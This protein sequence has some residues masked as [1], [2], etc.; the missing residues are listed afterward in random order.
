MATVPATARALRLLQRLEE[1][2]AWRLLRAD[3]A[4]IV[5]A[6]LKEHLDGDANRRDAEDLY[7]RIDADLDDLRTHGLSL[8]QTAQAY[9]KAWRDAGFLVRRTT[10]DTRTETLELSGAG[11]AA[12]RFLESRDAPRRSLTESRLASLS[13]QL[14][15]LAIDTDPSSERRLAR[16]REER[17]AI[18]ARIAA[19]EEGRDDALAGERATERVQDL[20]AQAAEVPDDFARVRTEFEQLNTLLRRRILESGE[21][22]R[23]VLDDVFRGVDLIAESD[24][25][26][27]F[28]GFSAL[29]LDPALGTAFEE[30]VRHVLER[31][32]ARALSIAERRALREFLTTL[33]DRSAEIHDVIT[34]FAR[35]LRRYVRSQ[36][37]QRDRVLRGLIQ[38]ALGEARESASAIKPWA[39]L[40]VELALTHVEIRSAG[41]LTLHDPAEM[42]APREVEAHAGEVA[43]LAALR[44]LAR[45][46]EI[47]FDEL[48]ND[49]NAALGRARAHDATAVVSVGDVLAVNPATQGVASVVGLLALAARWG[50]VPAEAEPEE[51]HWTG[52]DGARRRARV[53][54]HVFTGRIP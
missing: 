23:E 49:V 3:N 21:S 30:D 2:A 10:P 45:A 13:A 27:S 53:A 16:L 46:T 42:N 40:G 7:E 25:G 12:L 4:A 31:D 24:A 48:T 38:E 9:V 35:G 41:A 5:A 47:D 28:A 8:P 50:I 14:R 36:D 43:D 18:D 32:F 37:Y 1:D 34:Q 11:L 15:Q 26:R 20:L 39:Q 29:V 19:I 51:L 44:A 6:L 33:K 52:A 22:Q 17:A 54:R